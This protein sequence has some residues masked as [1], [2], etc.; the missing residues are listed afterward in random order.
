MSSLLRFTF[1][2][3]AYKCGK[4]GHTSK[5]CH[6][7]ET[8]CLNCGGSHEFNKDSPCKEVPKCLICGGNHHTLNKE[9]QAFK[10]SVEIN[11]KMTLDN[12]SYLEAK[13]CVVGRGLISSVP[14]EAGSSYAAVTQGKKALNMSPKIYNLV[15]ML[16]KL[17]SHPGFDNLLDEFTKLVVVFTNKV[18]G[19][20]GTAIPNYNLKTKVTLKNVPL[21]GGKEH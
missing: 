11:K 18:I 6:A 7:K 19:G 13:K 14:G 12:L 15:T 20:Q 3:F 21:A 9:C 17:D 2:L 8:K 16:S 1:P 5:W 4:L 10:N